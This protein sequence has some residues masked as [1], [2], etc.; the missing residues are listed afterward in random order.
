LTVG[1]V[2]V[3]QV[4]Y[5]KLPALM[6]DPLLHFIALG[7]VLFAIDH[8]VALRA[9]DPHT[10]SVD[11]GVDR[12]ARE[13]FRRER[14]REPN[15]EELHA[16]R[17]V[18]LDNEVLYREG[19]AMQ[20]DKGDPAI[21]E[22]VIYKVLNMIEAA[23]ATPTFDEKTLRDWFAKN[24]A[25][26]DQPPMYGF[27]EVVVADDTSE[28]ALREL[29]RRLNSATSSRGVP[30]RVLD[31]QP[32]D[33]LVKAYGEGF[34]RLLAASPRD[35]WRLLK[36]SIGPRVVRLDS[37]APAVPADFDK[38]GDV[39]LRDWIDATMAEQRSAAILAMERRYTVKV[40]GSS[41]GAA[42]TKPE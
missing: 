4:R 25:K 27:Q 36:S 28:E 31:S 40:T 20:I 10:I 12:G 18:W 9:D 3:A 32:H 33:S 34:V 30:S 11:I 13:A 8:V 41:N 15:A 39:V 2:E 1:R 14:G 37:V 22:R 6:R 21:R 23:L 16:L 42:A 26:Y 35:E 19:I 38:V 24:H 7:T 17:R 29:V 5:A